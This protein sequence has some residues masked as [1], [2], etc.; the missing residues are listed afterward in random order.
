MTQNSFASELKLNSDRN[1]ND[2]KQKVLI[3]SEISQKSIRNVFETIQMLKQKKEMV[4][5]KKKAKS[6]LRKSI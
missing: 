3:K 5:Q 1:Q 4:Y 2:Q 6:T